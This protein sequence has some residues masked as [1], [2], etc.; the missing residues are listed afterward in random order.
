MR[1]R[2][3]AVAPPT[4]PLVSALAIAAE[5]G[6]DL[7]SARTIDD[8][9]ALLDRRLKW[10]LPVHCVAVAERTGEAF[11]VVSSEGAANPVAES[12]LVAWVASRGAPIEIPSRRQPLPRGLTLSPG[13]R[14]ILA[15]PLRDADSVVGVLLLASRREEAFASTDSGLIRLIALQ[16]EQAVRS[17]RYLAEVDEAEA[18]VASMAKAVEAK[19]AYTRG[20]ADRVTTYGL[21]LAVAAGLPRAIR[22]VVARAGPLHDVGKIGVPDSV[23]TKPG[24]LSDAE[25]ELIKPHPVIGAEICAP[26]RSLRPAISGIRH[27]HE[28][29]DGRGYPDGLAGHSIPLEARVLAIADTFDALTSD[30]PY[31]PGMP[32]DRARSILAANEGPQWDPD[33]LAH[34][35]DLDLAR[36]LSG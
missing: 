2:E 14:A 26:L 13:Y 18:I 33:L 22:D 35:L 11:R 29:F 6:A 23:L 4:A 3:N 32:L 17:V 5:L 28:R 9:V 8:I 36:L 7:A 27:H 1:S 34:F 16:V 15:F 30:R 25:F 31:R 19:D 20:H 24:R 10:L 21:A 12:H